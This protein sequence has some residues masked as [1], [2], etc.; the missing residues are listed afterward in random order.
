[1]NE[2]KHEDFG[3]KIGGARKDLWS[4]RG[5]Y[6]DD[7]DAMNDREA[8][9]YVRKDNIWKK[10]DYAAM[11]GGGMPPGVAFFVKNVRD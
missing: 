6:A 7:L 11:I 5:L 2:R 4:G 10:P 1:M 3:E 8:E 9:K